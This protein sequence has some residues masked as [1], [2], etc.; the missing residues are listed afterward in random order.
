MNRD[1]DFAQP[2]TVSSVVQHSQL[3]SRA[4]DRTRPGRAKSSVGFVTGQTGRGRLDRHSLLF[5][6]GIA[7]AM[8]VSRHDRRAQDQAGPAGRW[9]RILGFDA[10]WPASWS[11]KTR[12]DLLIAAIGSAPDRVAMAAVA[13]RA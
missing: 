9:R 4:F 3:P 7:R 10:Q 8:A 2:K 6:G 1:N 11:K 12:V 5:Q 13:R